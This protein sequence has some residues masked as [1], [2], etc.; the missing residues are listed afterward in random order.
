MN[1]ARGGPAAARG[2]GG[3]RSPIIKP[4]SNTR[5]RS[6][7]LSPTPRRHY[8][9]QI[10]TGSTASKNDTRAPSSSSISSS[11]N[12]NTRVPPPLGP[13][14]PPPSFPSYYN[15]NNVAPLSSSAAIT[16]SS[17]SEAVRS[18]SQ[19]L[20]SSFATY[21]MT[22]SA[23]SSPTLRFAPSP[24]LRRD[25]TPSTATAAPS[26]LSSSVGD[27]GTTRATMNG[28]HSGRPASASPALSRAPYHKSPLR[29][30]DPGTITCS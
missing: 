12:S 29:R 1:R 21:G 9:Q 7:S 18:L 11:I 3:N 13:P 17:M 26:Y 14:P 27:I 19:S 10:S 4:N 16:S 20:D 23:P 8:Q 6:S 22:S 30:D 24:V 15:S 5:S 28:H 25:T 2:R